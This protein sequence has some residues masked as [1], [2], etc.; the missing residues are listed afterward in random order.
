MKKTKV[1][2]LDVAQR[3]GVSQ[4]T[5]SRALSGS[6]KV[7]AEIREKVSAAAR[8]LHY[9]V[10]KSARSLRAQKTDTI[11]VLLR[12]EPGW[13]NSRINPFFLEILGSMMHAAASRGY[14]L[15]LS[16]EQ[17]GS[18]EDRDFDFSNRADGLILLGYGEPAEHAAAVTL[19]QSAELPFVAS[20]P[21]QPYLAN[22]LTVGCENIQ[23]ARRLAQHLLRLKRERIAFLGD[24]SDSRLEFRERYQG[25]VEA[26][27]D[28]NR[29]ADPG[30]QVDVRE[31]SQDAGYQATK[32]L[33]ARKLDFNAI[34]GASDLI[35]MGAIR[36]LE[37][38]GYRV[39]GDIAVVGF[40]DLPVAAL[41]RP[42]LTTM[43]QDTLLEGE[44][45]IDSILKLIGGEA[46]APVLVP[47]QLMVRESCGTRLK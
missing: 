41:M 24:V 34:F 27:R 12:E 46:V 39:P 11:A 33:L 25:L 35:A 23:S 31:S 20:G 13:G 19:L 36:A 37:D 7:S 21:Q 22:T 26:L 32:S 2:S 14:E 18:G 44:I 42:A 40:D 15:L 10:D 30:L 29:I 8:E 43:R 3:A 9:Q 5:V 38:D 45:L 1:T 6:T 47:T 17:L 16:F 28:S 4:S